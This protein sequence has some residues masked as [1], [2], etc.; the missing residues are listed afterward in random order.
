MELKEKLERLKTKAMNKIA[1]AAGAHDT[2]LVSAY[3]AIANRIEQ[4]ERILFTLDDRIDSYEK[5]LSEPPPIPAMGDEGPA[6]EYFRAT[7]RHIGQAK[8]T[9]FLDAG[10]TRGYQLTPIGPS[11]YKTPKGLKVALAF[12]NEQR[13]NRWFLGV[14]DGSYDVVVLLCQRDSTDTAEIILPREFL[15]R[16]WATLSRSKGQVKFNVSRSGDSWWLLVPGHENQSA[17]AFVGAYSP[18]KR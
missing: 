17:N 4:D 10:K 16:Y 11:V 12:A 7:G 3:S 8:R 15:S 13:P 5:E 14:Q 9:A 6:P 2:R 1:N 18:L